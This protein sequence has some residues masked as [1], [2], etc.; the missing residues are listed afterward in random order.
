[1]EHD[2]AKEIFNILQNR[3]LS[4]RNGS[5]LE[6]P[7]WK[8][9]LE[10]LLNNY[11]HTQ[12]EETTSQIKLPNQAKWCTEFKINS[13]ASIEFDC[14]AFDLFRWLCVIVVRLW[15]QY[16]E[17]DVLWYDAVHCNSMGIQ[18]KLQ[19][20]VMSINRSWQANRM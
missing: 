18:L 20:I 15:I 13:G 3:Q 11:T 8:S 9:L 14:K 4:Y 7:V 12:W 16:N 2:I 6:Q 5:Y 1:M 19:C 10:H 17:V